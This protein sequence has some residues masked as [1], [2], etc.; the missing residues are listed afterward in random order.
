[1]SADKRFLHRA[2]VRLVLEHVFLLGDEF[3]R[4]GVAGELAQLRLSL[5]TSMKAT[6]EALNAGAAE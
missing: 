4:V 5:R 3:G 6:Q 2:G 1:M